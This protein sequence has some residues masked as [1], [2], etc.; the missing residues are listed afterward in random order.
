[1]NLPQD[2][3]LKM[4]NLL[5]DEYDDFIK[6]YDN[7]NYFS[8]RINT[9]KADSDDE[10]IKNLFCEEKVRWAEN[11]YYYSGRQRPGKHPYH[12]AGAY[13]IQEAS[14]M[15]P[16]ARAEIQKGDRVLDLCA[17]PGGK[18]TGAAAYLEGTGLLVS[19][20]I[21]PGRAKILS[22]NIERMGVKNAVVTNESPRDLERYFPHFFDKIIVDAPCSGEGMF[23]KDKAAADQWSREQVNVCANRQSLILESAEKM[24]AP[25]GKIIYSTCTFSPEENE[26]QIENFLKKHP[27]FTVI[28]PKIYGYFT[29]ADRT[30]QTEIHN[31]KTQ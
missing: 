13:Y 26:Q 21:V 29:P 8:L 2:F 3:C 30:G 20:E 22:G 31:W 24:L 25:D 23:R 5:K 15:A 14:A 11:G 4:Q 16:V 6:G 10:K 17:A 7:E 19:N 9:L 18:S 1:M 12:H 27:E 28:K